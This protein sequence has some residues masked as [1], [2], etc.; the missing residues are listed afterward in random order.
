MSVTTKLHVVIVKVYV[1]YIILHTI[2]YMTLQVAGQRNFQY[3]GG[4]F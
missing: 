4:R 1:A 3:I 2:H